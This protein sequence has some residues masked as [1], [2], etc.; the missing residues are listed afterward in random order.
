MDEDKSDC[1]S[2]ETGGDENDDGD[3]EWA[4]DEDGTGDDG[5]VD[6]DASKPKKSEKITGPLKPDLKA[7]KQ[8]KFFC[9]SCSKGYVQKKDLNKHINKKHSK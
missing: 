7:D 1:P 9:S 2:S 4:P 6:G 3:P 8:K 5:D